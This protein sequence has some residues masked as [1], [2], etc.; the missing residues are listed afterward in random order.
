MNRSRW[1][2]E[3]MENRYDREAKDH[4]IKDYRNLYYLYTFSNLAA[5][6]IVCPQGFPALAVSVS[7]PYLLVGWDILYRAVRNI[8]NGQVFDENFLMTVATFGRLWQLGNIPR[9]WR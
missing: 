8:R 4:E 2:W 1:L 9:A 7:V 6:G 5:Y 3:R